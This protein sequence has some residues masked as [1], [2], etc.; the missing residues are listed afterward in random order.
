[1]S[2]LYGIK[3]VS[4]KE[5]ARIEKEAIQKGADERAFMQKAGE[6]V[7]KRVLHFLQKNPHTKTVTLLVG[8][9]NNGG[10]AYVSGLYLLEKNIPVQAYHV[11]E[12]SESSNLCQENGKKFLEKGGKITFLEN[13]KD[14]VFEKNTLIVDG[15]LGTGF[16]G[17]LKEDLLHIIEKIDQSALQVFS[18]DIPSGL[19]GS[20]GKVSTSAI[21]AYETIFL[22]LAKIGFFIEDG[23]NHIGKLSRVNFGL[24]EEYIFQA[25]E[26]AYLIDEEFLQKVLPPLKRVRHKYQA[27]Y[28]LGASGSKG[29]M[30][31]VKLGGLAALRSGCGIVR[32]FY[33]ED[34][35]EDMENAPLELISEKWDEKRF[36]E[37]LKRAK[38]VFVGP[39]MGKSLEKEKVFRFVISHVDKPLVI[40]ADGLYFLSKNLNLKLPKYT[41]ITPHHQEMQRLLGEEKIKDIRLFHE[42]CTLNY[43]RS[44]PR[45]E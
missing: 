39:G 5:M 20:T 25:K 16:K 21:S 33:P 40:D 35:E 31:A 45:S 38:A 13:M 10:D 15:L 27:G 1:M 37:E 24:S 26:E 22:G 14:L 30:G 23:Y 8:K 18:I 28:V 34:A 42:E 19:D 12:F 7:F 29:M 6:G 3:V 17:D 43:R 32:L 41:I 44:S 36:L 2:S 9:G 11:A 4:G